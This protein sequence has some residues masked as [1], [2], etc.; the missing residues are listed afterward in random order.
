MTTDTTLTATQREPLLIR[1]AVT[2]AV[3]AVVHV[4]VVLGILPISEDAEAGVATAVDAVGLVVL[5]VW[6][7][8]AL[9][10]AAKVIARVTNAGEVVAGEASVVPTGSELEA[11]GGPARGP[12]VHTLVKPGLVSTE[13]VDRSDPLL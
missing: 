3:A 7:R 5:L 1:A 10:P 13:Y 8:P 12:S 11:R 9:V 6:A 2:A 4:G